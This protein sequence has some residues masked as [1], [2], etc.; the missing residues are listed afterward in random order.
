MKKQGM[1]R[2]LKVHP[3]DAVAASL[4]SPEP[5]RRQRNLTRYVDGMN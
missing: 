3:E 1:T 5:E 4:A 2:N